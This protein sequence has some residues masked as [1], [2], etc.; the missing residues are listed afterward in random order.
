M[1]GALQK[2]E[3]L[4][5]RRFARVL[6]LL[7]VLALCVR[8]AALVEISNSP[9]AVQHRWVD[10]DMH[11]FDEWARKIASGDVLS[12]T[13]G[14]PFLDWHARI[15]QRYFDEQPELRMRLAAGVED[16]ARAL[17]NGWY[18]GPQFHQE[19]LYAYLV[20][21]TY[22]IAGPRPVAVF[23]WQVLLGAC[24][25]VLLGALARRAFGALV[26]ALSALLAALCAPLVF[27]ELVL[28]RTTTIVFLSLL[29]A[30]LALRACD[31]PAWKRAALFGAAIGLALLTNSTFAPLV[32][33]L[34]VAVGWSWRRAGA[35]AAAF[36]APVAALVVSIVVVLAPAWLR[37]RAVGAPTFSTSSVGALA[38]ICANAGDFEPRTGFAADSKDLTTILRESDTACSPR[39][40]RRCARTAACR[41]GSRSCRR[42][43]GARA[44]TRSRTTRTSTPTNATA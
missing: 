41:I 16:P 29:V 25:V 21:A 19:P 11:F 35:S 28:L 24:S 20:G 33:G 15:A 4:I 23:A 27:H 22:V 3:P 30:W 17:W 40:R 32:L 31:R 18:G 34:L 36:R 38:F 1:Q 13:V 7:F 26:G 2:L 8:V 10:T 44:G 12:A 5:E 9:C 43:T 42:S 14:H 6:A 37:N 39:S